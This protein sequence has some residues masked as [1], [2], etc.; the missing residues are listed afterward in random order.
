[1]TAVGQS[2]RFFFFLLV[3][4]LGFLVYY[5]PI[6]AA[7]LALG[8]VALT[9]RSPLRDP[10]FRG[11]LRFP[12]FTYTLPVVILLTGTLLR[13]ELHGPPH[14]NWREPPAWYGYLLCSLVIFHAS[15]VVGS[16]IAMRGARLRAAGVLLP[17][18]WLSVCA[19]IS[20]GFAVAGVG[21]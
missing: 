3:S 14:P 17:G 6:S 13:Y 2:V 16:L 9:V 12:S 10:R 20:A 8:I 21:L 15:L 1:M 11:R 19:F 4:A 7:V 18:L 5:W